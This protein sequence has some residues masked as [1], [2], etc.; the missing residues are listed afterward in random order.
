MV[1]KVDNPE[2]L[3]KRLTEKQLILYGVG[4]MGL[5]IAEWLDQQGISYIL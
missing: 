2:K 5:G 3:K 4:T 1:I